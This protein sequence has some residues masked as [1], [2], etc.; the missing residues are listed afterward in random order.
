MTTKTSSAVSVLRFGGDPACAT[1]LREALAS[2]LR[3]ALKGN[4]DDDGTDAAASTSTTT[5]LTL[6]NRYFSARV[7]LAST[8]DDRG[9]GDAEDGVVLA[10]PDAQDGEAALQRLAAWHEEA[11]AAGRCGDTLRLCAA[12]T[13]VDSGSSSSTTKR[14]ENEE[15][16]E[17]ARRVL[18]CLDR[19]YEYVER[20]DLS[21]TGV[22][23][24]FD[25]R[26]KEGF[27]RV[28]E[29]VEAT[30]WSGAVMRKRT[31]RRTTNVPTTMTT[32]TA[33]SSAYVPPAPV[34]RRRPTE[35]NN[36]PPTNSSNTS[37]NNTGR[38]E[39]EK[40]D[41]ANREESAL[42]SL[43]A[44]V[45]EEKSDGDGD[46][47]GGRTASVM[48]GLD[49]AVQEASR[50]RQQAKEGALTD[51]ERRQ[52]AG[53]VATRLMSLLGVMDDDEEDSDDDNNDDRET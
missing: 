37:N 34:V 6:T 17:Y 11:E 35:D 12:V 47:D 8:D 52:R 23:S 2:H 48:D 26:E 39:G 14:T 1:L 45:V 28:V 50:V 42:R 51:E 20:T 7:R 16:D 15:E 25:V 18:W 19:G 30:V 33:E 46:G 36:E 38:A 53:D 10:W 21:A 9:E 49:S 29:A 27:A 3:E 31:T 13:A 5:T 40:N 24:G 22:A 44:N 32:A 4:D 43:R 41:D